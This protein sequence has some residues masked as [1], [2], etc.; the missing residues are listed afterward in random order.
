MRHSIF[1]TINVLFLVALVLFLTF[2]YFYAHV[3]PEVESLR[4]YN[5]IAASINRLLKYD[6][7]IDE[8]RAYLKNIN[9]VEIKDIRDKMKLELP[10]I[11]PYSLD[12]RAS[13]K[14]LQVYNDIYILIQTHRDIFVY[15]DSTHFSWSRYQIITLIGVLALLLTYFLLVKRLL[16]LRILRHDIVQASRGGTI[17]E[18]DMSLYQKDEIGQLALSFNMAVNRI[19]A[20]NQSRELFLRSIM[21]ELKTPI[22]VGRITAE[23]LQDQKQKE[24]LCKV[25]ERLN[26]LID[27]FAR[28]EE[29]ASKSYNLN[30]SEFLLVDLISFVKKMLLIDALNDPIELEEN[31]DLIKADFELFALSVKNLLDNAIKYSTDGK[32][33]VK[34][35]KCDLIISNLGEPLKMSL[36]EYFKPY[37]KEKK[38]PNSKGFGLGMY[39]I[40]NTL[41][42][43]DLK[44]EYNYK[45]G[46]NYFII[47]D[48]IVESFC[49]L[50]SK[51]GKAKDTKTQSAKRRDGKGKDSK[52]LEDFDI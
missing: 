50:P 34:S 1:F 31:N 36:N 24:R 42:A 49:A 8:I 4:Q 45:D 37:F 23:M 3:Q 43:Q 13:V 33:K 17:K 51:E 20:L 44:I 2:S 10:S 9:F 47:K 27:E 14:I 21:H 30:K 38:N 41:D 19:K 25:F 39:I 48:C 5:N 7:S 46:T 52:G 18:V 11:M 35:S 22:T 16:P 26:Q 32:V 15:K 6:A 12:R 40:K 29:L 28:V